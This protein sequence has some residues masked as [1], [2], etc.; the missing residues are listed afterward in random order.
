M[1]L[2]NIHFED[3]PIE[4][5]QINPS[6]FNEHYIV[7]EKIIIE[8]DDNG[9]ISEAIKPYF[10]EEFEISKTVVINSGVGQGKSYCVNHMVADFALDS[11]YIVIVAVPFNNLIKQY[12]NDI[13]AIYNPQRIFNFLNI[14]KTYIDKPIITNIFEGD[15]DNLR[16]FDPCDYSVHIMTVN[17]LLGNAGESINQKHNKK[18]YFEKIRKYCEE[19][20]KKLVIFFDEIHDSIH[21]FE[22]E[23]LYKLWNFQGLVHKIFVVSATF[24]ESSKEVI[25]YLSEFTENKIQII[26]SSRKRYLE[27]QSRLHINFYS[28]YNIEHESNLI[29]LISNLSREDKPFDIMVYSKNLIKKF[30]TNPI[31]KKKTSVSHFLFPIIDRINRCYYDSFDKKNANKKYNPYHEIINIGTNFSTGININKLNHHFIII[32]PK[33]VN[34]EYFDNKGVFTNGANTVIQALARQRKKGDIHIFLPTP[35]MIEKESL[36]YDDFKNSIIESAFK[37]VVFAEEKRTIKYTNI[38]SQDKILDEKYK[39]LYSNVSKAREMINSRNR[40]GMN[41]LFY[42]TKEIFIM[43]KGERHLVNNFFGG[44]LSS[45]IYWSA[46]TNQFLNCRL[47]S[48]VSNDKIHLSSQNFGNEVKEIFTTELNSIA[49]LWNPLDFL[50]EIENDNIEFSHN[51]FPLEIYN[52]FESFFFRNYQLMIDGNKPTLQQNDKIKLEIIKLI[53]N[54]VESTKQSIYYNYLKSCICFT[55]QL[56][57]DEVPENFI[58]DNDLQIIKYFKEWYCFFELMET[59]KQKSRK[60]YFL[61]TKPFE[62]FSNLFDSLNIKDKI[63]FILSNDRFLSSNIFPMKDTFSKYKTEKQLLK[64]FYT[65]LVNILYDGKL[66]STSINKKSVN[67]YSLQEPIFDEVALTNFLHKPLPEVTL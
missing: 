19:K 41:R 3:T 34:I 13:S 24:N 61:P 25:K 5:K 63:L 23:Y 40:V 12:Y 20:N 65:L 14:D 56:N 60:N 38:N 64:G 44:D 18:I 47:E 2:P 59:H 31:G 50:S 43:K 42:P 21:N 62:E 33:D 6:D 57:L 10:D 37:D 27:K 52:Y 55:N 46:I 8:P 49:K 54:D 36:P 28:G 1:N 30:L 4:F 53:T 17:A 66:K 58:S 7:D 32:F 45:Y 48:I 22:E 51:L 67:V 29:R 16:E 39:S 35:L 11:K 26:E 9:Y 15:E